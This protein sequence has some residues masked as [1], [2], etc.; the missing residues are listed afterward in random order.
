KGKVKRKRT[1]LGRLVSFVFIACI[2]GFI[3]VAGIIAWYAATLP[4]LAELE[5]PER[6]PNIAL[7][8]TTGEVMVNRGAMGQAIRLRDMPQHLPRA[9]MAV[10]DR[11]FYSHWGVDPIGIARAMFRNA[12]GRAIGSGEGGSTITQQLAKNLFLTNERSFGRK[13][14]ELILALWLEAR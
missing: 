6:P 5:V 8:G 3:G 11:R 4:P 14:Q 10:E 2:W 9:L 13:V 1:L 12:T 7:V